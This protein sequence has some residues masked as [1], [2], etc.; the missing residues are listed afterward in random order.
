MTDVLTN[1]QV[2]ALVE[3]AR[4]GQAPESDPQAPR[5]R[6]P[7]VREIDFSRPSKFVQEQQRRL[8]SAHEAF[9]RAVATRL[10]AELLT[11]I[12]MEVLAVDQLT[13]SS[14]VGQ[15]PQPSICA[16]IACDPLETQ[17]L[18]SAELG[19]L[20]RMIERLMGGE[21]RTRFKPRNLTEIEIELVRG[22][23]DTL[24]EQLTITW[25]ELAGVSLSQAG[26][27][28][29][30]QHVNL[31]PPSEP[32]LVLTIEVKL[33]KQS[34]TL[35]LVLPYRSVEQILPELSASQYGEAAIDPVSVEMVRDGVA[36][37]TVELRA[38]VASRLI[39]IG[40]V[41]A[42]RPGD[43][44]NF[45]VPAAHGVRLLAE[46]VPTHHAQ[47]GRNGNKRAVQVVRPVEAQR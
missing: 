13:W 7:R 27:E 2:E 8:E 20:M 33:E 9:C 10:S 3:A 46:G 23:F 22:L 39:S 19:L 11:V 28:A 40:D 24:I 36:G 44:V 1:D 41:L 26:L 31:A 43:V 25:N 21:G 5:R 38:E 35:S 32:T 12:E 37:V 47:P 42:L 16:V 34:S 18:L 45:E 17:V 29:Q 4:R 15:I 6:A 30:V 14:A